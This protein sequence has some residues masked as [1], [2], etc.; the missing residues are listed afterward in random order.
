MAVSARDEI[1]HGEEEDAAD[2]P[3]DARLL[4][5]VPDEEEEVHRDDEEDG[6]GDE[7]D[8]SF[9]FMKHFERAACKESPCDAGCRDAEDD[10]SGEDLA[11]AHDAEHLEEHGRADGF[12]EDDREEDDRAALDAFGERFM[13]D[14]AVEHGVD[15]A[16]DDDE[17]DECG[18][19]RIIA[20]LVRAGG[21]VFGQAP[22]DRACAEK[23]KGRQYPGGEDGLG[24]LDEVRDI[25][26]RQGEEE[27]E[28]QRAC[29][30]ELVLRHALR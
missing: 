1:H 18:V 25:G 28:P 30:A 22:A 3:P 26:D 27:S 4:V 9:L 12:V 13:D 5:M 29:D 14:E 2:E 20:M 24:F 11:E 16:A 17:R 10:E 19:R 7:F 6:A 15:E 23:R 21:E 8:E